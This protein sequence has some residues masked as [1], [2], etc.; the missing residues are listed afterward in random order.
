MLI[1]VDCDKSCMYAVIPRATLTKSIWRN[2][3]KTT[4]NQDGILKNI[5]V[6]YRKARKGNRGMRSRGDRKQMIKWHTSS[7]ISIIILNI[8]GQ[9]T[10]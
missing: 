1:P 7:T 6:T 3:L 4:I 10:N 8:I 9:N 5:W 2:A